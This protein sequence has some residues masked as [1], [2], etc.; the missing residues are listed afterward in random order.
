MSAVKCFVPYCWCGGEGGTLHCSRRG[1]SAAVSTA[2]PR[3][4]LFTVYERPKDAPDSYVVRFSEVLPGG[5]I[6]QAADKHDFRTLEEA[7]E[8]ILRV[9]P[10]AYRLPRHPDDDPTIREVW[11]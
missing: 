7:R 9:H 11:L 10:G 8:A 2:N 6:R 4:G 3:L 1:E 5:E